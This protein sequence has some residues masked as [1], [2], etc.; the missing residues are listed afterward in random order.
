MLM[1]MAKYLP[2]DLEIGGVVVKLEKGHVIYSPLNNDLEKIFQLH[3]NLKY[4]GAKI[5]ILLYGAR[6]SQV[7]T[8]IKNLNMQYG[9]PGIN[10]GKMII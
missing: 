8:L 9:L 2:P 3:R 6:V 7:A 4:I 10:A 1:C 5:V